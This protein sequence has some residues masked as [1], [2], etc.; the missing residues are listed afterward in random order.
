MYVLHERSVFSLVV[1]IIVL[2]M[3]TVPGAVAALTTMAEVF[4]TEIRAAG[5]SLA[6]ALTVTIF[7]ASTQVVIT[8]LLEA[9][10]SP[11]AP[12]FYVIV[13]SAISIVAMAIMRETR[14]S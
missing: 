4:P 2:C 6:Y 5:I 7:G 11:L 1:M 12:A 3:V 10:G 13:T 9:T 8:W 14:D